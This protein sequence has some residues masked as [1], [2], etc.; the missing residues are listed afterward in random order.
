MRETNVSLNDFTQMWSHK[1]GCLFV[2]GVDY[3]DEIEDAIEE[4]KNDITSICHTVGISPWFVLWQED[5]VFAPQAFLKEEYAKAIVT[6]FF[7]IRQGIIVIISFLDKE[8]RED[9]ESV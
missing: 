7:V 1:K 9:A 4:G 6:D 2:F 5:V 8:G 3:Y